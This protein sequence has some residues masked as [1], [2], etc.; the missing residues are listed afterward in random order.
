MPPRATR[1]KHSLRLDQLSAP[2][3][4][5]SF[6]AEWQLTKA[7]DDDCDGVPNPQDTTATDPGCDPDPDPDPDPAQC[8][9]GVSNDF[10]GIA[11]Y[12]LDPGCSGPNDNSELGTNECDNGVDD[13][14]DGQIDYPSDP[15]CS[16]PS[17]NDEASPNQAPTA[18]AGPDQTVASDAANVGFDGTGSSDPDGDALD[19]SWTQT[20]GPSVTLSGANTATPSFTAPSGPATLTFQL[21]VC[22]DGSPSLC[23]TDV[24]V[25]TVEAPPPFIDASAKVIVNGP[26]SLRKDQK[27]FVVEVRNLGGEELTLS[28]G[29]VEVLVRVW[30]PATGLFLPSPPWQPAKPLA[31][32][33]LAPGAKTRIRFT[34]FYSALASTSVVYR[35][36]VH[37]AGDVNGANDCD[38]VTVEAK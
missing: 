11:D 15:D 5:E 2:D 6:Q 26:T 36:C 19:Y 18:K 12:P 24:V 4:T 32:A 10:D 7:P 33:T 8:A 38:D 16:G 9:D 29:D 17:G 34:W 31:S 35:G 13:D 14:G 20:G 21:E 23:D 1:A 3:G 25:I 37:A 30:D 22:D 28:P 27:S